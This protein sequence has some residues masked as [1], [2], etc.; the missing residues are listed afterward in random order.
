[1]DA[2]YASVEQRDHPSGGA[3]PVVHTSGVIAAAT[4]ARK[5]WF[6]PLCLQ[7]ACS[8][9][10]LDFVPLRFGLVSIR[11]RYFQ[12]IYSLIE[13]LSLDE[14]LQMLLKKTRYSSRT[15]C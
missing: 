12:R 11:K 3:K 7:R 5:I 1:M 14:A 9:V 13:P 15:S 4:E 10:T 2:F 6:T 8:F